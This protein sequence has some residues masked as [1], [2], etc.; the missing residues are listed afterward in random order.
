MAHSPAA[1]PHRSVCIA[2]PPADTDGFRYTRHPATYG[3]Q[4]ASI[5]IAPT[6]ASGTLCPGIMLAEPSRLYFPVRAPTAIAPARAHIAPLRCSHD[7]PAT[8]MNPLLASQPTHAQFPPSGITSAAMRTE[9][10]PNGQN[11]DR[12]AIAPPG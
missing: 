5:A 6:P 1:A 12:S 4:P 10:A 9:A 3:P 8:S 7:P 2:A 11:R